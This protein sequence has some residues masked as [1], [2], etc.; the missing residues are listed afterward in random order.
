MLRGWYG[1]RAK[2]LRS[3][4]SGVP[5]IRR[6][7]VIENDE[8]MRDDTAAF[9]RWNLP[10]VRY[11]IPVG[12]CIF[13]LLVP[14]RLGALD[15]PSLQSLLDRAASYIE[16]CER[17][18]SV[19]LSDEEYRQTEMSDGPILPPQWGINESLHCVATYSNFRRFETSSRILP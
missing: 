5:A 9:R 12:L 16:Q 14:L 13:S 1:C 6:G 4:L 10:A 3:G 8:W 2:R 11:A 19:V 15:Q 17:E 7:D 18:F